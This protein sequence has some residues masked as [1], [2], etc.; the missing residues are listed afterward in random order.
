MTNSISS[1]TM[2]NARNK[3]S[4]FPGTQMIH[5]STLSLEGNDFEQA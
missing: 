4:Y 5:R 3:Q 1:A 2:L